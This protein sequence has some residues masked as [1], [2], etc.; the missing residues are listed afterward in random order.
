VPVISF[1]QEYKYF[2]QSIEFN[3]R[4]EGSY[5]L[6]IDDH[7][8]VASGIANFLE[9]VCGCVSTRIATTQEDSL[10]LLAQYGSP[11]MIVMDFWLSQGA[12]LDLLA[13]FRTEWPDTPVLMVSG[14]EDN[15]IVKKVKDLGA[16]GYV[17]KHEAPSRFAE[18]VKHIQQGAT[19]FPDISAESAQRDTAHKLPLSAQEFGLTHR[20]LEVLELVLRGLPNK[21]I[22]QLL[23]LSEQTIKEHISA[24]LNKLGVSNRVEAITLLQGRRVNS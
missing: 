7:P 15:R 17:L 9:Q 2:M 6:V 8:L 20:Q 18:A 21:R 23:A 11:H 19:W 10:K 24:I 3:S 16:R 13:K 12:S 22:A 14:D 1:K 5:I 4:S